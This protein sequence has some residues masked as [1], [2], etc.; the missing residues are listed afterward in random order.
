MDENEMMGHVVRVV[1]TDG[2][3]ME[4]VVAINPQCGTLKYIK[5]AI[6]PALDKK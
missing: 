1:W 2:T 3:F 5:K 6:S 4:G